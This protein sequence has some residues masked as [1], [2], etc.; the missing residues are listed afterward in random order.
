[1]L[2]IAGAIIVAA[3]VLVIIGAVVCLIADSLP[4]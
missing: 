2:T 4:N 1:M 3:I